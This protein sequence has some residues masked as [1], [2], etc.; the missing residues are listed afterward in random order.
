MRTKKL[1]FNPI[2]K[3]MKTAQRKILIKK[4]IIDKSWLSSDKK[5]FENNMKMID[6]N[7]SFSYWDFIA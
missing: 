5:F 3:K 1:K 2:M 6:H 7:R 4:I